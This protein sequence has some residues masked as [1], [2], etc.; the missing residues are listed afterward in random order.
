[1]RAL[2]RQSLDFNGRA[3]TPQ[4]FASITSKTTITESAIDVTAD[5][6]RLFGGNGLT[7]AFPMEKLLRDVRASVTEDGDNHILSLIAGAHLSHSYSVQK[8]ARNG[9]YTDRFSFD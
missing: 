9:K 5:C 3:A 6:L 4:L 1:M 8:P 2:M 7:R